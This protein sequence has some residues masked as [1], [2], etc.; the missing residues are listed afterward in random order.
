MLRAI[1]ASLLAVASAGA[2]AQT[3]P[4]ST[5][6]TR[7]EFNIA[8]QPLSQALREYA[9]QSGDQ[10]VFYSEIGK[11]REAPALSGS[12]TRQEAL[13]RLLENTGLKYRRV[14][15]KTIA[16]STD[17]PARP[18]ASMQRT[19]MAAPMR[20]AQATEPAPAP[21]PQTQEQ[22]GGG[23][24]APADSL[25][26]VEEVI[27]TGTAVA[28]RTKFDSSVAISTFNAEDIAQQAPSSSADLISAVPGF[29]VESTAGTTQGNVFARGIIQDGGYRYVGLMEDGIPI[30][31]VFELSF[32]NPDQF[33]RVDDTIE[34]VEALRGGT[35]PI[36]TAGAVGGTVNFVTQTAKDSA[37]GSV[38]LGVSDYGMYRG[39][40]AWSAPLG[41]DWG[42]ALGGYYRTSDGVRDPGY[43][44]DEGGQF[45]VKLDRSFD[46]G[47]IEFFGKYI[48]D[49]SLFVVPIPLT[50]DPSD[51][52][53]VNGA[54]A[55]TYSL[56]SE[57]L[58]RAG[59]PVTAAEV[60]LRGSNL[61]DGIHPQLATIG[62]KLNWQFNDTVSVTNLLRYTD[63]E[64]RFDG[65]FPGDPPETGA[66]FA[67]DL[68][69]AANYTVLSTGAPYAANQL[70][71][72][73]GHWVVNKEFDAI[74]DDLRLNLNFD[75]HA[76]TFG[77]YVADY[78]MQDAW[79]L[80]NSIL[81]DVSDQPRRLALPG[82]TDA[83]GFTKYSTFNL[84]TD[85]DAMA[86]S[87]YA[88]D[89][90]Q[91]TDALRFDFGV[92][93]DTQ[94][95]EGTVRAGSQEVAPGVPTDLDGNPATTYDRGVS[96][97][98]AN[99]STVDEDFDNTGFSIGINYE[100][101]PRHGMFGHYTDSAKL[102]HF[103]DVR[104]GVLQKDQVTNIELGYKAS[105]ETLV[106]F[107]TL[108]QTEFDNVPF[109]DI[110]A[111]GQT[112]VRR[113]ETRTRGVELEGEFQPSDALGIRFSITQQDPTYEGFTGSAA[114][115]TGNVIR[116]I[117]K[118]M[119]RITPTYTFMDG[120][121]RA[122]FTYT[123]AGKR[124]AND[125]NSIELPK[126]TKLDAGVMFD[127]GANW[128]FQVTGD[129]LTD[130]IGL[131]E[132][133]PRTDVGSGGIGNIYMVRPLFGRSFM[134][135]VTYRWP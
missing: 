20:L 127:V 100:F 48:D 89:E 21:L 108:F 83:N 22:G 84:L 74:Q 2:L 14:N 106:V 129:N 91:V 105:L 55:G 78:S 93:Y 3:N 70:V 82:V 8:A 36:F 71:Q 134:G 59:L 68:G 32:Y 57:D 50:G 99:R 11:G 90:W 38:K 33:V 95:I 4:T 122:Y 65:I 23:E 66:V 126:Y 113:A 6:Q 73:H 118:T 47:S 60:G 77:L 15:A 87:L 80:G 45:R 69:V 24:Q 9:Q 131:T 101:T 53:G 42:I 64:V 135:S 46:N 16:I 79:S 13:Q 130:E 112:I 37:R 17:A 120:A 26:G 61:E 12:Y 49:R 97:I 104:N 110:L 103:D 58:A 25:F 133:N 116:R 114:G 62:G 43:T 18:E 109:Q 31:P 98:G 10:V 76:V 121:A 94:D 40:V 86:Y 7:Q 81:M 117:P 107:A 56:H 63:G 85:Y 67:A 35:A 115:N 39:D 44:A 41:D 96:L 19:S 124:F 29:W 128:T 54:D 125:E 51:P 28:E 111:N 132:G 92:R 27:V 5:D 52:R 119:A 75:T 1:I 72:N 123:Y 88:A 30:Y 34:R 102:P